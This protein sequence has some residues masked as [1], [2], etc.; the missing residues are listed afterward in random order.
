MLGKKKGMAMKLC[1][2]MEYG[3]K[4]IFIG[5]SCR[6]CGAK[7]SRRPLYNFGK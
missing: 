5:K 6:K 4:N 2:E 7:A 1:Q 3:I